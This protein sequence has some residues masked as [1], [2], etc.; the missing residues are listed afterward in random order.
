MILDA[1]DPFA[2]AQDETAPSSALADALAQARVAAEQARLGHEAA[3]AAYQEGLIG[4]EKALSK[5][6]TA[7]AEAELRHERA[8]ALVAQLERRHADAEAAEAEAARAEAYTAAQALRDAAAS[9][10][11]AEYPG[12]VARSLDLLREI[13]EA[14]LAVDRA[15]A[16]LPAGASR[17]SKTE[18]LARTRPGAPRE[19]LSDI[20]APLWCR[21]DSAEPAPDA[22]Q[23]RV[24]DQGGGH[25]YRP[26]PQGTG[27]ILFTRRLL[28]R[29][30]FRPEV[31]PAYSAPLAETLALP[32]L[33]PGDPLAWTPDE[34]GPIATCPGTTLAR[35]ARIE[36]AEEAGLRVTER[37][38]RVEHLAPAQDGTGN[39][40]A[41]LVT[42]GRRAPVDRERPAPPHARFTP[43]DAE[44]DPDAAPPEQAA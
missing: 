33:R 22:D 16:A 20:E 32:P 11:E 38:I 39:A 23:H 36:A 8:A 42:D 35:I 41:P 17:L 24:I 1:N 14:D 31:R 15:N 26:S 30:R 29:V 18:M 34:A 2:L 40:T 5:L 10:L 44:R 6:A 25:G 28:R 12:L 21:G 37:E 19:V 27:S 9:R 43:I 3:C 13:S 4:P 7:R